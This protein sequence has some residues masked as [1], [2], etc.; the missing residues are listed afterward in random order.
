MSQAVFYRP[1]N[2]REAT[3][4]YPIAV[5]SGRRLVETAL[6]AAKGDKIMLPTMEGLCFEKIKHIAYLEA[7]GNYTSLHFK[8]KRQVLVCKTLREVEHMLPEKDFVRIHRSHTIHLKHIKKYVRGKG[9]YVVLQNGVPL[10]VS[11][12]QKDFF[13]ESLKKYFCL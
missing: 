1:L 5:S 13:L 11:A 2:E 6:P 10:T 12:G 4:D 8:D 7:N 3:Q 9:G